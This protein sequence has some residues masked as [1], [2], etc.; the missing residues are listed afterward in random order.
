MH[1]KSEKFSLSGPFGTGESLKNFAGAPSV[2]VTVKLSKFPFECPQC[3]WKSEN[4]LLAAFGAGKSLQISLGCFRRRQKSQK[5]ILGRLF[6]GVSSV[7]VKISKIPS[8]GPSAQ[9]QTSQKIFWGASGADKNLKTFLWG[10]FGAGKNLENFILGAF[11][12]QMKIS[13]NSLGCLQRR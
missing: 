4:F 13:K 3:K 9:T 8:W 2:Q 6:F 7:Q 12:A 11:G 10:A 1:A 5:K